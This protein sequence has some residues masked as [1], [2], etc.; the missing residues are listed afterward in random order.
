M[1]RHGKYWEW[2]TMLKLLVNIGKH[3]FIRPPKTIIRQDQIKHRSPK[4][5]GQGLTEEEHEYIGRTLRCPDCG[6]NLLM[7]PEGGC[8][9]NVLCTS[10]SSEF[11]VG[12]LIQT[13][14]GPRLFGAQRNGTANRERQQWFGP[15]T[16][17]EA[18]S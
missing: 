9:V 18:L 6:A 11:C 2:T 17:V 12:P 14:R 13:V 7:G 15:M 4:D 16:L 1:H 5:E 3:L 10:C 8:S